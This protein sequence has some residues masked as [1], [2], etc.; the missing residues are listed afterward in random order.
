MSLAA[1]QACSRV[2]IPATEETPPV[3]SSSPATWPPLPEVALDLRNRELPTRNLVLEVHLPDG[4][5]TVK[6]FQTPEGVRPV[7]GFRGYWVE[8][9]MFRLWKSIFGFECPGL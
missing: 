7:V 5:T 1:L 3:T 6:V 4:P 8:G 2:D 9:E